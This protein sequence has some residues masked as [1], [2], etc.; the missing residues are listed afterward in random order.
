[1]HGSGL[2]PGSRLLLRAVLARRARARGDASAY[3]KNIT[4]VL[5][6]AFSEGSRHRS[7]KFGESIGAIGDLEPIIHT[8]GGFFSC[9]AIT[10]SNRRYFTKCILTSGRETLFWNA[11]Q[12][13]AVRVDGNCYRIVPPISMTSFKDICILIFPEI[14]LLDRTR[15]RK[16]RPYRR[17]LEKVIRSIAD[18]NSDHV[19]LAE[20]RFRMSNDCDS[21]P[22]P[23]RTEVRRALATDGNQARQIVRTLRQIEPRWNALRD[24]VYSCPRCL[25]HM[26]FG[27]GNIVLHRGVGII[28]DFGHVGAAPIGSDLHTVLRYATPSGSGEIDREHLVATYASVFMEKGIDVDARSIRLALDAHFAVR[29]RNL[30]LPSARKREAFD[31]AIETSLALL[32]QRIALDDQLVSEGENGAPS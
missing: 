4:K 26:D 28:Q 9:I 1:M 3:K 8:Q 19:D 25:C 2:I 5:D 29:Y 16:K 23:S 32:D 6:L 22:L 11:W 31:A 24:Q 7:I 17:H 20:G 10:R 12:D 15:K 18:F 21:L 14:E 13:G 27:P 30:R